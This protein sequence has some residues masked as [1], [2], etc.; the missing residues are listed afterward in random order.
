M[1]LHKILT[2]SLDSVQYVDD[3]KREAC[4]YYQNIF[5]GNNKRISEDILQCIPN[6][7]TH[8]QN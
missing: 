7:V 3:I 4:N 1:F 6:M 5:I 8:E 2:E